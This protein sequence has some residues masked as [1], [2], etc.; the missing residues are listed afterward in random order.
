[1]VKISPF[2]SYARGEADERSD[3]DITIEMDTQHIAD[4]YFGSLHFQEDHL[5]KKWSR[6]TV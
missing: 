2:G 1:M 5:Q 4:S 3:I 6:G